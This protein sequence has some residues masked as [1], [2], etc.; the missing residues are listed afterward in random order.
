[1]M[2]YKNEKLLDAKGKGDLI[3][4]GTEI[5]LFDYLCILTFGAFS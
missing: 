4:K 5:G 2:V 1:M 3:W